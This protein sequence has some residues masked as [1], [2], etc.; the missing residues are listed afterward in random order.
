MRFT[1]HTLA[2]ATLLVAFLNAKQAQSQNYIQFQNVLLIDACDGW[3][4]NVFGE[5]CPGNLLPQTLS[6]SVYSITGF[7]VEGTAV[8][9]PTATAIIP[10]TYWC[11]VQNCTLANATVYCV[12]LRL[13][14]E[15]NVTITDKVTIPMKKL[16]GPQKAIVKK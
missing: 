6:C 12:L 9:L 16:E 1:R 2:V 8:W 5:G 11:G 4:V 3:L 10:P 7:S 13:D 15:G 14:K